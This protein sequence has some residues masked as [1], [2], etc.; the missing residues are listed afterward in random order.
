MRSSTLE[1]NHVMDSMHSD[2]GLGDRD[3][4]FPVVRKNVTRADV[5]RSVCCQM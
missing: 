3:M 1:K 2:D 4:V 5:L